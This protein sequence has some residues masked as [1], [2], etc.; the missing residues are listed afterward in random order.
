MS[1]LLLCLLLLAAA[2]GQEPPDVP[3]LPAD[4]NQC[5]DAGLVRA[6]PEREVLSYGRTD[7]VTDEAMNLEIPAETLSGHRDDFVSFDPIEFTEPAC[8]VLFA[9]T[10]DFTLEA[11]ETVIGSGIEVRAYDPED[12][13]REVEIPG[14]YAYVFRQDRAQIRVFY[15]IADGEPFMPPCIG[16]PLLRGGEAPNDDGSFDADVSVGACEYST[17]F[18]V[19]SPP[20]FSSVTL[21]EDAEDGAVY[22]TILL[23]DEGLSQLHGLTFTAD[24]LDEAGNT[25]VSGLTTRV[26]DPENGQVRLNTDTATPR[27]RVTV[28]DYYG[29][30]DSLTGALGATTSAVDATP[31]F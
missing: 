18:L 10:S 25:V 8:V 23:D 28:T 11:G 15:P 13:A 21:T 19:N 2:C 4:P 17:A 16:M 12:L 1:R 30:S 5:S 24:G 22:A 7:R 9:D 6:F 20:A 26:I 29:V 27:F 31:P 3:E 14:L